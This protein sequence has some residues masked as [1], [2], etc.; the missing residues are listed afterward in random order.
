MVSGFIC[1][2]RFVPFTI[3]V[4]LFNIAFIGGMEAAGPGSVVA[5]EA[6][7]DIGTGVLQAGFHQAFLF[8]CIVSM[9]LLG[10]SFLARGEIHKDYRP[11]E[12]D[13]GHAESPDHA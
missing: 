10:I 4:A 9:V 12:P 1:L 3:G 13:R 2:E 5:R 6:L 8:G 7:S 11:A